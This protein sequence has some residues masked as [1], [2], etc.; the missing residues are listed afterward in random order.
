[1]AIGIL[2]GSGTYAL[3][4]FAG[5]GPEPV[6]TK[7]G[8]AFVSRGSIA[9]DYP[10]G[11]RI[12]LI[13]RINGSALDS[14]GLTVHASPE[15]GQTATLANGSA[16][17]LTVKV[18][19]DVPK[20]QPTTDLRFGLAKGPWTGELNLDCSDGKMPPVGST[21]AGFTFQDISEENRETKLYLRRSS[22]DTEE[23]RQVVVVADGKELHYAGMTTSL[24]GST[25]TF[26][27]P[28][29]NVTRIIV[30]SRPYEWITLKDVALH[31]TTAPA[32]GMASK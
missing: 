19:V 13:M 4:G 18:I 2:T 23:N 8:P 28:K 12:D 30:R 5:S 7:W 21:G 22:D 29:K 15:T 32:V 6:W 31:P 24:L 16:T 27:T 20:D 1:M 3:P 25:Y 17:D 11:R 26:R 10:L 14:K 9:M